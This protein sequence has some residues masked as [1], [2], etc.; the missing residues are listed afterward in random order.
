MNLITRLWAVRLKYLFLLPHYSNKR[1]LRFD[2]PLQAFGASPRM[3]HSKSR[4]EEMRNE[5]WEIIRF[6]SHQGK[7]NGHV[8]THWEIIFAEQLAPKGYP[9]ALHHS[10]QAN[11]M[12]NFFTFGSLLAISWILLNLWIVHTLFQLYTKNYFEASSC[13]CLHCYGYRV[14]GYLCHMQHYY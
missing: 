7:V 12:Y 1:C 4:N 10:L 13:T 6:C 8:C 2:W 9:T 3:G 11:S 14:Y 5:K